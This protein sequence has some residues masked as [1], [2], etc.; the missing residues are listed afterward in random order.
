M[1][2]KVCHV[3][4]VHQRYDTR[5][6]HKEC[7][8]LAKAGYDVTLLV[9]DNKAPEVRNG[10][11][12]ISADFKP[13]SRL[14]R[15]LH[16]GCVMFKYAMQVDAEIYH[17]HDPELLPVAKKLKQ[18]GKKVIF[19]SHEDIPAQIRD[20]A[21]IPA[22]L[23]AVISASCKYYM[24][25]ILK[26]MDFVIA[27]T[28]HVAMDL[29][30]INPN[31]EIVTNYPIIDITNN[32]NNIYDGASRDQAKTTQVVFAGGI[33]KQWNHEIILH[34]ITGL[35]VRYKLAGPASEDY[36]N[37]LKEL[38]SWEKVDYL[39]KISHKEVLTLLS[40]SDIGLAIL[41]YSGNTNWYDGTLSNTKLFEYMVAGI[42]VICTNF[43]LWEA[44]IDKYQC[45]LYISPNDV[46]A[47][48][49]SIEYLIQNPQKRNE[50][51]LNGY[52]AVIN[53]FNWSSEEKKL[54]KLYQFL[55]NAKY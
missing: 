27:A 42:P 9:A 15:I 14:D 40:Q 24:S 18:N 53:E 22:P 55:I 37:L 30:R 39:G 36:M 20:K 13:A 19:D 5:I 23:R 41:Q 6:F 1:S 48:R 50:M 21:W 33:T 8:S 46:N 17:L 26:E 44:I 35:N 49:D 47:L 45:G 25:K 38:P 54:I 32:I 28:P 10:L 3:T 34:A 43:K 4:S 2:V 7:T 16:S 12:I 11:K 29:G 51:G 52:Q 31:T